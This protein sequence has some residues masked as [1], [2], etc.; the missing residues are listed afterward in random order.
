LFNAFLQQNDQIGS[1]LNAD[2][3]SYAATLLS[4]AKILSQQATNSG[5]AFANPPSVSFAIQYL[6]NYPQAP[7]ITVNDSLGVASYGLG[8]AVQF[9]FLAA[10]EFG[11]ATQK[12]Q[13]NPPAPGLPSSINTVPGPQPPLPSYISP[14]SPLDTLTLAELSND[15]YG[16]SAGVGNFGPIPGADIEFAGFKA[17]ADV[18]TTDQQIVF[19]FRGTYAGNS[20]PAWTTLKNVLS[21]Q[22]LLTGI[23]TAELQGYT[24][25][26][27][28]FVETTLSA[29]PNAYKNFAVTLTGHSLGGALAQLVGQASGFSTTAFNAPGAAGLYNSLL[30][31]LQPVVGIWPGDQ[32]LNYRIFGDQV[33]ESG[34]PIGT[35]LTIGSPYTSTDNESLLNVLGNLLLNHGIQT[36]ITQLKNGATITPGLSGPNYAQLLESAY[37][38]TLASAIQDPGS[39][40]WSFLFNSVANAPNFIDPSAGTDFL[41]SENPGSPYLSSIA[42]PSLPNVGAY[43]VRYEV[44]P[45]WSS[46]TPVQGGDQFSLPALVSAV[47][48]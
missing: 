12:Q 39:S 36:V 14:I 13:I 2:E 43:D 40:V 1:E 24:A 20:A 30:P 44:G 46:F 37:Q 31:E 29:L 25:A 45:T 26:A 48:F 34:Q 35:T 33:S 10:A 27:A 19:A 47:D 5:I 17:V 42:F 21:D 23:P 11:A 7:V 4:Y 6:Q 28:Q 18:D 32:N 3:Q 9:L 15:V 22:S 16:S 38:S 8:D 41:F